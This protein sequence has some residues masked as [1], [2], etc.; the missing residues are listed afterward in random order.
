MAES[1][2]GVVADIPET[3]KAVIAYRRCIIL[4]IVGSTPADSQALGRIVSSGFLSTVKFWLDQIL[5]GSVGELS[6][7]S[8]HQLSTSLLHRHAG[9]MYTFS[10][11]FLLDLPAILGGVDLLLHLL[12][13]IVNLPVTKPI[14]KVSGMGKA[15]GSIEKHNICLGTPNETTIKEKVQQIKEAW[16][17]SVKA[18]KEKVSQFA[19]TSSQKIVEPLTLNNLKFRTLQVESKEQSGSSTRLARRCPPRLRRSKWKTS[20]SHPSQACY[21]K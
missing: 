1:V 2:D 18:L 5:N 10:H 13:N 16:N 11:K 6:W 19:G 9:S 21:R 3:K 7:I 8:R 20:K 15:V 12:T 14:V 17:K 4:A